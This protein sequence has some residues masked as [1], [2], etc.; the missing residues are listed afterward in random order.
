[1]PVFV[2]HNYDGMNYAITNI[3]NSSHDDPEFIEGG[4]SVGNERLNFRKLLN[5]VEPHVQAEGKD[6]DKCFFFGET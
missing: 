6:H 1:M 2:M 4:L 3:L 5:A